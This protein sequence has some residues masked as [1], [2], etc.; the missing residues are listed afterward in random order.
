MADEGLALSELNAAQVDAFVL[1]RHSHG[2]RKP[3]SIRNFKLL[4]DYLTSERLIAA[5]VV[6]PAPL[7]VFLLSYRDWMV[8]ERGLAAASV[9]RYEKVARQF[10]GGRSSPRDP[11]GVDGLTGADVN[12]FLLRECARVSVVTAKGLV[13]ALRSVLRFLFLE[14]MMALPLAAGVPPVAGWHDTGLPRSISP[15]QVQRLLD[16]C[17]T[18]SDS[19]KRDFAVLMVLARLGLRSAE[20]A[21]MELEDVDWRAGE[22]MVRGKSRRLDRL[23][24]P[25]EV[26]EAIAAYLVAVRDRSDCRQV[27]LSSRAPCRP[28]RPAVVGDVVRRACWRAGV[29]PAVGAHRLRHSLATEMLRQG[30]TII[31]ISQVLRH[32]NLATTS[33]YAKVDLGTLGQVARPWPGIQR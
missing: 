28:I 14:G 29:E 19:G 12:V 2:L 21:R 26:G 18:A 9:V 31:D 8:A 24:L 1:D 5:E 22:V 11:V 13:A 33:V 17:D 27:F 4:R 15:L 25:A 3:P 20:V 23:P 32:R 16:C 7:D 10:L 6:K 30:A